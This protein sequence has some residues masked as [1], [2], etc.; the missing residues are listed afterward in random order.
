M[1]I[2][3]K[4]LIKI[5]SAT[6]SDALGKTGAMQHEM[7]PRSA[8]AKMAG[9][10]FTVRVHPAD[11]LMVTPALAACPAGHVLVIDGGGERNT[12]LWGEITTEAAYR[13][14]LAGVV[15]NGALRDSHAI[16]GSPLPVFALSIV[17]NAGGAEYPGELGIAVACAGTVVQ[18]GDWLVGDEDGVVVIPAAQLEAATARALE[19]VAAEKRI[20]REMRQGQELADIL[21]IPEKLKR[22]REAGLIPQLAKQ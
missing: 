19:I 4:Q 3:P 5:G 1:P 20:I 14:G 21:H 10:A 17:P 16:A 7:R 2:K 13:K 11:I 12:A 8:Q 15:I 22:K 9:P 18:P 6:L